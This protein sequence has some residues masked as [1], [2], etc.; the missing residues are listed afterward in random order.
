MDVDFS[1]VAR[2]MEQCPKKV[3]QRYAK[4]VLKKTDLAEKPPKRKFSFKA[5]NDAKDLYTL[6]GYLFAFEEYALCYDVCAIYDHVQFSGDYTLWAFVQPLR[7]MQIDILIR[8]G[9]VEKAN[10]MLAVLKQQALPLENQLRDWAFKY[11]RAME[12]EQ[13][14]QEAKEG[15]R[16]PS[17]VR[18]LIMN[19]GISC[20]EYIQMGYLPEKHEMMND[21]MERIFAFLRAEEK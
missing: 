19:M 3:I 6:A 20:L 14:Y 4:A 11:N 18:Y 8:N 7:Q 2:A 5:V 10:A 1:P 13:F 12:L 16:T 21:W 9:E 17:A 15:L